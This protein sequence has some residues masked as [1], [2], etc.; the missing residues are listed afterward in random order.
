MTRYI[1]KETVSLRTNKYNDFIDNQFMVFL[2]VLLTQ[3]GE[4]KTHY[5]FF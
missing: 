4:N 1:S 2:F 5:A 3:R